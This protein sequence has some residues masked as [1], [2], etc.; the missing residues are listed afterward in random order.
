[1]VEIKVILTIEIKAK[2][3][4]AI[5]IMITIFATIFMANSKMIRTIR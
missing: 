1:M 3:N 5:T 4:M 2:T